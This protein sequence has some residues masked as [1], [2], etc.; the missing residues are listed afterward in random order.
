MFTYYV[1][2]SVNATRI[3]A[4]RNSPSDADVLHALASARAR[5]LAV[6]IKLQID[7]KDGIW[8]ANIGTHFTEE[9]QWADWFGN[10]TAALLHAADLA[11]QAGPGVLAGFNVGTELDGTHGREAEWRAVIAAVRSALPGVPLWL[12]PNWE[13]K[14]APGYTWVSFFDALDFLGVDMYAPLASHPDPTLAEAVAGWSPIIA[15]LSAFSAAHGGK[16]FIFAEI[17]YASFVDAAVNAP[18]CCS[19]PPDTATQAV[20]YQS[21]FNAVWPQ[22]FLAGVFFW[23]WPENSPGGT[24]CSTGFDVFRKPAAAIVKAAYSAE[25]PRQQISSPARS[26]YAAPAPFVIFE[27]GVT[28]FSDWSWSAVTSFASRVDPYPG[29]SLAAAAAF[30]GESGGLCF[31]TA[32]PVALAGFTALEFDIR[33]NASVAA[34]CFSLAASLCTC[35]D[36]AACAQQLPSVELDGYAP[37]SAPCTLPAQ[38]DADP[39]SAH[40]VI[41]LAALLGGAAPAGLAA[42]R[43]QLAGSAPCN[44]AVDSLRFT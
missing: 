20:L 36:C 24:P 9:Q 12:G 39:A 14:N 3:F 42:A 22:P 30:T 28:S 5:G 38:W 27:N 34:N 2:N 33:A 25:A 37:A 15:N 7:C 10:Y 17:G 23:A 13:W 44:F 21:F 41:P 29:H 31:R 16:R 32:T 4:A 8:R 6:A 26:S 19:G 35:D 11:K 18:A 43:L 40:L 1:S